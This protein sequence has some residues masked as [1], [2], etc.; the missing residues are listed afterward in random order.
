MGGVGGGRLLLS[1]A[2]FFLNKKFRRGEEEWTGF[3][4]EIGE[5]EGGKGAG[6]G[7]RRGNDLLKKKKTNQIQR[8]SRARQVKGTGRKRDGEVLK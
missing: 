5:R 3:V 1:Y 7:Q 8:T 4:D 6:K 2:G